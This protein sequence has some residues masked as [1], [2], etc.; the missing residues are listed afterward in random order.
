[1]KRT[2][3]R[4][5]MSSYFSSANTQTGSD[6]W[7]KLHPDAIFHSVRLG[8][9][10]PFPCMGLCMLFCSFYLFGFSYG[11]TGCM[12]YFQCFLILVSQRMNKSFDIY[13]W[14]LLMRPV[15]FRGRMNSRRFMR[16]PFGRCRAGTDCTQTGLVYQ[17]LNI[18][19][20]ALLTFRAG[21]GTLC[22]TG[23]RSFIDDF[24]VCRGGRII[25]WLWFFIHHKSTGWR[26]AC[27]GGGHGS[28]MLF[29]FAAPTGREFGDSFTHL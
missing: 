12:S 27:G 19:S 8:F 11:H 7:V 15:R 1:M 17:T 5:P 13:P 21:R 10:I 14:R 16:N 29:S 9:F 25:Y 22:L 23:L 20:R 2:F 4:T 26:L 3:F 24:H 28:W 18:C 6:A